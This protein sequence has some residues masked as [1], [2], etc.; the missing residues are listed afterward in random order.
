MKEILNVT[1]GD[2]IKPAIQEQCA[3]DGVTVSSVVEK[4]LD[5]YLKNK[6]WKKKMVVEINNADN[7]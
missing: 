1:V 7:I 2:G 3:K 6:G 5:E 4:L